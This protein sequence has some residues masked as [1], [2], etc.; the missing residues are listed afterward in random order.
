VTLPTTQRDETRPPPLSLWLRELPKLPLIWSSPV[1]RV[2]VSPLQASG[3]RP[4]II[5]FPGILSHDTA[6][7]LMRRSLA[8]CGYAAYPS[9]LGVITGVSPEAFAR[10]EA[11]LDEIH[12]RHG[13]RVVLVG[14]SLG[15]L[16]A[17]VLAQR[18]PEKVR[19]VM[20]LG[21]PFSGD[22]R[23]NNAWRV[24]EALN[25]HSVDDPPLKDDPSVKPDVTTIAIWSRADGVVAAS[26]A[27]GRDGERDIAIE[28]PEQHFEFSASRRSIARVL[29]ILDDQLRPG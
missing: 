27:R 13:E 7:S 1:R 26:C 3:E 22:R 2:K 5:V 24:Y 8:A 16:F 6:T 11:R 17:R 29:G 10:A 21:T 19:L 28:V 12:R 18:S 14:V 15:G 25:R 20:T 9:R 23:A 4:P